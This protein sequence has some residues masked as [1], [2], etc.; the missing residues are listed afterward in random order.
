MGAGIP[1]IGLDMIQSLLS[2]GQEVKHKNL[3]EK[4]MCRVCMETF[5]FELRGNHLGSNEHWFNYLVRHIVYK[6]KS[7]HCL[8][9]LPVTLTSLCEDSCHR[10]CKLQS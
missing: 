1:K 10:F 7:I 4:F 3:M 9:H 5:T 2:R 8:K 6:C